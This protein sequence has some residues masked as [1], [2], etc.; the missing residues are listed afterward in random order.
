MQNTHYDNIFILLNIVDI[1]LVK[2]LE[3]KL[4]GHSRISEAL[5]DK[6]YNMT[7]KKVTNIL[8]ESQLLNLIFDESDNRKGE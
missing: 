1:S 8:N 5:I 7:K 6:V 4:P 2:E 3:H